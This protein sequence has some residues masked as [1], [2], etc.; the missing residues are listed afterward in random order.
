MKIVR[1]WFGGLLVVLCVL[2]AVLLIPDSTPPAPA[3]GEKL[4]FAWDADQY[5]S[6]LEAQFDSARTTGC[7]ALERQI[8][9]AFSEIEAL[10][11]LVLSDTLAPDAPLFSLIEQKL[12]E[13]GTLLAACPERLSDYIT[14]AGRLRTAIKDQSMAWDINS[15]AARDRIYRLL[16]GSRTAVEE[17][18]LQSPEGALRDVVR[19]VDE[20]SVTPSAS[21][22]GVEIHSGDILVSRGGAPTSALIARGNDYPGNFSH[23][24]LV[25]IEANTGV[26]S[27]IEAHI[28][29]G[30]AI[31]GIDDY[32][33]DKKSRVM[34]LR[35]RADLTQLQEDP[36]LPHKAAEY[37]LHRAKTEAIP[38]DFAMNAGEPSKLFCSEVASD[39]YAQVGMTLWMGLS[40]ISSAGVNAWLQAFGVENFTT[41]EPSDLEYDPQLRV[42]A[43]WRAY[44]TLYQDR[45]DNAVV[46]VMLEE[47]DRG[48]RLEY[49]WYMLPLARIAKGYSAILNLLG[50]VGPVPEGMS[51]TSALKNDWFSNRHRMIKEKLHHLARQ[52]ERDKGYLPPYWE[53]VRLARQ[54][55]ISIDD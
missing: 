3:A 13:L 55:S 49:D 30:V 29:K 8:G 7:A 45:L 23:V 35:L 6:N 53:L 2:Y 46:D 9:V 44:E 14:T 39:A 51:A 20:P 16:Y 37:A 22:L 28:E 47:A 11:S 38:Y 52:F 4:P 32:L 25:H 10:L 36:M 41:Q 34:V 17:V 33:E 31:A 12:F 50:R 40:H 24:A 19:E 15:G 1:K 5:W 26:V 48:R 21:I 18:M 43:E 42:V 27:I 54:A